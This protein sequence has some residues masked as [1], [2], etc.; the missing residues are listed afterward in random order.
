[1][2]VAVVV[3]CLIRMEGVAGIAGV[4]VRGWGGVEGIG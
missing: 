3:Q 4:G 2:E 1:M